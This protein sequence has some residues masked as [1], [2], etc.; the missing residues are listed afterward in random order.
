VFIRLVLKKHSKTLASRPMAGNTKKKVGTKPQRDS[1][2]MVGN[3]QTD[4]RYCSFL[5][6]DGVVGGHH[7]GPRAGQK[8]VRGRW[9]GLDRSSRSETTEDGPRRWE[10]QE[11]DVPRSTATLTTVVICTPETSIPTYQNTM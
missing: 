4:S 3:R 9:V 11:E 6:C 5:P 1:G 2:E 7:T 10:R 8:T